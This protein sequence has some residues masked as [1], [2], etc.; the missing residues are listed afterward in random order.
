MLDYYLFLQISLFGQNNSIQHSVI[1]NNGRSSLN[2]PGKPS[3][4][5]QRYL[6]FFTNQI[7]YMLNK[8]LN[9]NYAI[10]FGVKPTVLRYIYENHLSISSLS[11]R[12]YYYISIPISLQ[13]RLSQTTDY[14]NI[15]GGLS[16]EL[17]LGRHDNYFYYEYS[18]YVGDGDGNLVYTEEILMGKCKVSPR[19]LWNYSPFLCEG[20]VRPKQ[21]RGSF[22]IK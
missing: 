5:F 13:K 21:R 2:I 15:S 22:P 7:G 10:Q 3:E 8:E 1:F 16:L 17:F 9:D 19:C 12:S 14:W 4:N 18:G 11:F 20:S 6:P